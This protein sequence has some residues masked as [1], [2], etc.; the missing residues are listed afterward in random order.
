MPERTDVQLIK[1]Y[2]AG[3]Q[4]SLE[5]LFGRYL[6]PI[7]GYVST[8][9]GRLEA[10]DAVQETFVRVWKHIRVFDTER[11]F[12]T[13]LYRIAHNAA[14]DLLKKKRPAVFSDLDRPDDGVIFEETLEDEA[15]QRFALNCASG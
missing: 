14:L 12:K 9:V 2:L 7:Y 11:V 15:R 13:W 5:I 1:D 8:I 6:R 3:D 10:D 4:A